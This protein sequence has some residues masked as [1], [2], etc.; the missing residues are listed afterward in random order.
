MAS[1][2]TEQSISR[3]AV[4]H[5][6]GAAL[7]QARPGVLGTYHNYNY[8]RPRMAR[9]TGMTGMQTVALALS[10]SL[11]AGGCSALGNNS[12]QGTP[13]PSSS[14]MH[15]ATAQRPGSHRSALVVSSTVFG[16]PAAARSALRGDG[17]EVDS[18][19][20]DLH[21]DAEADDEHSLMLAINAVASND[22]DADVHGAAGCAE[23]AIDAVE[24]SEYLAHSQASVFTA[25]EPSAVDQDEHQEHTLPKHSI[26]E[27]DEPASSDE[28]EDEEHS[29]EE[30]GDEEEYEDESDTVGTDDI[31]AGVAIP[32][33]R[34]KQPVRTRGRARKPTYADRP[35]PRGRGGGGGVSE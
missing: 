23:T 7:Q 28:D 12:R 32:T 8:L 22:Q 13:P 11:R 4:V 17:V 35:R 6:A 10:S 14:D 16:S 33:S 19:D 29:E 25:V 9:A 30:D 2:P 26:G 21:S 31:I 5:T 15:L 27:D 34:P 1:T 3:A 20:Q 18:P 24:S